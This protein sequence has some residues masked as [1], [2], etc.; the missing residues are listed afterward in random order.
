MVQGSY[1]KDPVPS[2]E[3]QHFREHA[4]VLL[5]NTTDEYGSQMGKLRNL[6]F[7]NCNGNL[8]KHKGNWNFWETGKGTEKP[9]QN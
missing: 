5:H 1:I 4:A 6:F 3:E 9:I 7:R 2:Q 8:I